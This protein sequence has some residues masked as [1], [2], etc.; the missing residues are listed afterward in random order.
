MKPNNNFSPDVDA[1]PLA[2][3]AKRIVEAFLELECIPGISMS[4]GKANKLRERFLGCVQ[5]GAEAA[6]DERE[7]KTAPTLSVAY[8]LENLCR[9]D[10]SDISEK[11]RELA[12]MLQAVARERRRGARA[13]IK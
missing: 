11:L 7:F 12:N 4:P 6:F 1:L 10:R 2:K 9:D 13:A 8:E 3:R 5:R